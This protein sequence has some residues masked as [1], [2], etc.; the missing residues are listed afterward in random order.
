MNSFPSR[1]YTVA[2]SFISPTRS[3]A[4]P[5]TSTTVDGFSL[6]SQ[7]SFFVF[8]EFI[9]QESDRVFEPLVFGCQSRDH[10]GQFVDPR[11]SVHALQ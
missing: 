11:G 2:R 9:E 10:C 6:H 7:K 4:S 8:I 3:S 5:H 1:S